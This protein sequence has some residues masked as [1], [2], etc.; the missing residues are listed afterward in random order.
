MLQAGAFPLK[1]T[2]LER[3]ASSA[4]SDPGERPV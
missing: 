1:L 2:D 4:C 3:Q